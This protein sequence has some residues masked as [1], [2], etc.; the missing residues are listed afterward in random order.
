[1]VSPNTGS[2]ALTEY[3]YGDGTTGWNGGSWNELVQSSP[4]P[5]G[6][7]HNFAPILIADSG[8]T[9]LTFNLC[10]NAYWHGTIS[11]ATTFYAEILIADCDQFYPQSGIV[12]GIEYTALFNGTN[13]STDVSDYGLVCFDFTTT[14]SIPDAC[15][16]HA[17][18][19]LVIV[20]DQATTD[21]L[22]FSYQLRVSQ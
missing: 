5:F 7:L 2:P 17:A 9:S 12:G 15:R 16:Y 10:G 14:Y 22:D 19:G 8:I 18:V 3:Y 1:M 21:I 11:T 20:S 6:H 13:N 4:V